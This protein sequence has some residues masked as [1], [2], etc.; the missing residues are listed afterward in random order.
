MPEA[1]KGRAAYAAVLSS[2]LE[3]AVVIIHAGNEPAPFV[4]GAPI[5]HQRG[6]AILAGPVVVRHYVAQGDVV[7]H[8]QQR[9][10]LGRL[11]VDDDRVM[12]G[13]FTHFNGYGVLVSR[14]GMV[15]MVA[16]FRSGDVLVVIGKI[17][18]IDRMENDC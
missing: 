8:H 15:R 9:R 4:P 12:R 5:S 13:A 6:G 2:C 17:K 11:V 16:G 10:Q 18:N 3:A 14:S 7:A 1:A